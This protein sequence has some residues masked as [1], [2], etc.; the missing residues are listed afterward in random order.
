MEEELQKLGI[1]GIHIFR[2]SLLL[3]ERKEFRFGERMAGKIFGL[4]PF[5][6]KGTLKKV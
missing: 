6:F 1:E 5:I 3:G 2:P 4:L